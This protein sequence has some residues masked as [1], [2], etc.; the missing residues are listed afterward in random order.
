M[1]VHYAFRPYEWGIL[2]DLMNEIPGKDNYGAEIF[3]DGSGETLYHYNSRVN[4]LEK[5][6]T[7]Y[8]N[9]YT[10]FTSM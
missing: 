1:K 9:R 8:Y 2:D 4:A 5:L 6:N 7:A 10:V 3:D